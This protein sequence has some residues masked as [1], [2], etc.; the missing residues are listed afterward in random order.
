MSSLSRILRSVPE[1]RRESRLNKVFNLEQVRKRARR[2]LPSVLFDYIDGG[3][4]DEITL[5]ANRR[6]FCSV[7]FRPS[8]GTDVAKPALSSSVLG[9]SLSMPIVLAPCG[10]VRLICPDGDR[11]A[12]KAASSMGTV[13]VM[14]SASATPLEQITSD[15]SG[16]TWFQLYLHGDRRLT[17]DLVRRAQD[18]GFSALFITID[19]PVQGNR[20]RDRGHGVR[21]PLA[22]SVR[23]AIHFGPQL[24]RRPAWTIG[25][26]R[27][28][29]PTSFGSFPPSVAAKPWVTAR[30]TWSEVSWIREIWQGPLVVKGVLTPAAACSAVEHGADGIVISNHGGRQLDGAPASLDV[31]PSIAQ[32]VGSKTHILLDGGVR[33]GSDAIKAIA[34]GA[35]A[36]MI[37]R[38]YL[39]GLA[40]GGY[41]GV[42]QVLSILRAD[43]ER[44]LILLGCPSID[45]VTGSLV[46]TALLRHEV[47]N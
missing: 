40:I 23:N 20:E 46:E 2:V 8:A 31:L 33:R 10:G 42:R 1:K 37:G 18:A 13:A 4:D 14:S 47:A 28:G 5:D 39:Y 24:A 30:V 44:T 34:L 41:D 19:A 29:L 43:L 3:A 35:E 45:D 7:S 32:E 17:E 11:A 38:P 27:D 36:V 21:M 22:P 9:V 15:A 6:A 25:Y 16:H 26:I 12:A